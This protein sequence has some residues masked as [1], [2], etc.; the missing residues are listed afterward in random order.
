MSIILGPTA[1]RLSTRWTDAAQYGEGFWPNHPA[2]GGDWSRGLQN[3]EPGLY[4][5]AHRERLLADHPEV[6]HRHLEGLNHYTVVMS[7]RGAR[8]LAPLVQSAIA[9]VDA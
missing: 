3:A 4:R 1:E 5:A 8:Q 9:A 7:E 2:C 6:A